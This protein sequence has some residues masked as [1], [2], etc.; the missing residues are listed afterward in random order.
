MQVA[1]SKA[2]TADVQLAAKADGDGLPRMV[3]H[4]G[5]VVRQRP[6]DGHVFLQAL[7]GAEIGSRCNHGRFRRTVGV[8]Q[9]YAIAYAVE[10]GGYP[11]RQGLLAADGHQPQRIRHA[12]PL[13]HDRESQ[14]MPVCARQRDER[15][16]PPLA[17]LEERPVIQHVIIAQHQRAAASQTRIDFF[18]VAVV[19]H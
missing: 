1:A 18:Y 6:P 13:G 16:P 3:Q 8:Q 19:A 7:A 15:H 11:L 12:Q 4:V 5:A 14:L 17:K 10:P 2:L 9:S